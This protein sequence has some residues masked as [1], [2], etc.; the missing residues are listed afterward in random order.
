MFLKTWVKIKEIA[1]A[2]SQAWNP[3]LSEVQNT[4][5]LDASQR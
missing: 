3:H 2:L 5:R 1:K 4:D